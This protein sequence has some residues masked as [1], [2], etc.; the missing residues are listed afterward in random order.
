[1]L[2]V[3][4]ADAD[5]AQADDLM[6]DRFA[7]AADLAIAS[8]VDHDREQRAFTGG[9][10]DDLHDLDVGRRGLAAVQHHA[11]REPGHCVV[12]GRLWLGCM[13]CSASSPSLVRSS[14]PSDS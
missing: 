12:R 1:M 14:S 3:D 5:T 13:R 7:H 11:G 10:V 2:V 4:R 6:A 8:F 9:R